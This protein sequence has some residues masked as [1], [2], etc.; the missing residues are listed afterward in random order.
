MVESYNIQQGEAYYRPSADG[1]EKIV[2]VSLPKKKGD[3]WEADFWDAEGNIISIE[4]NKFGVF[5]I[6]SKDE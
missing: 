4:S 6:L 1:E 2:S 5:D 3:R